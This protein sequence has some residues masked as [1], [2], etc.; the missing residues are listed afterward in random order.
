M[1][2][3]QKNEQGHNYR[4]AQSG[5]PLRIEMVIVLHTQES[6]PP[7]EDGHGSYIHDFN[8]TPRQG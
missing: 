8:S 3:Y 1:G 2:T 5:Q 6:L 7:I 4:D